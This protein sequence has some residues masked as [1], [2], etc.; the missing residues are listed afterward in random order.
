MSLGGLLAHRCG[1]SMLM[2]GTLVW[3]RHAC[4]RRPHLGQAVLAELAQLGRVACDGRELAAQ[5]LEDECTLLH[6]N[7]GV[8]GGARACIPS[9]SLLLRLLP[10]WK[11]ETNASPSSSECS[12]LHSKL[13]LAVKGA[14]A[15]TAWAGHE[16]LMGRAFTRE[17]IRNQL[18]INDPQPVKGFATGQL[19]VKGFEMGQGFPGRLRNTLNYVKGFHD[20]RGSFW[21]ALVTGSEHTKPARLPALGAPA[22]THTGTAPSPIYTP[23]CPRQRGAGTRSTRTAPRPA[24]TRRS[25][26][27]RACPRT[28]RVTGSRACRRC[29]SGRGWWVRW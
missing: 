23:G 19:L 10:V 28:A 7:R 1:A 20:A 17:T 25:S 9:C 27:C 24:P 22:A 11:G 8:C 12:G 3:R 4:N 15:L 14:V 16:H 26:R 21:A 18:M 29:V 6:G 5:D 13:L 2:T